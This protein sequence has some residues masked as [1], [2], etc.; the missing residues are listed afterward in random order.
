MTRKLKVVE[1]RIEKTKKGEEY[2]R[3]IFNHN[4]NGLSEKQIEKELKNT[5]SKFKDRKYEY[6]LSTLTDAYWKN[7]A[8]GWVNVNDK[9]VKVYNIEEIY[10]VGEGVKF[11]LKHYSATLLFRKI[12]DSKG[13]KDKHNDCLYNCL[14]KRLSS[15]STFW[16]YPASMKK[17]LKLNRD[18]E[19]DVDLIPKIEN[20]LKT[21]IRVYGDVNFHSGSNYQREIELE[22]KNGHYSLVKPDNNMNE[23]LLKDK[24]KKFE[25]EREILVYVKFN[26]IYVTYN[27]KEYDVYEEKEFNNILYKN[28]SPYHFVKSDVLLKEEYYKVKEK[29]KK[30]YLNYVNDIDEIKNCNINNGFKINPLFFGNLKKCVL[31]YIYYLDGL[32][33]VDS[34]P[35]EPLEAE[36]IKNSFMGGLLNC[37]KGKYSD[38]SCYDVNSMYPYAL[39]KFYFPLKKGEFLKIDELGETIRFGIYR[40]NIT[41]NIDKNLFRVNPSNYYTHYDIDNALSLG[42]DVELIQ[43]NQANALIYSSETRISGA[44]IFKRY[45]EHFYNLK[46]ALK[47]NT[48]AK[49][50]ITIVWG[51]LCQKSYI[52]ESMYECDS[53]DKLVEHYP[54]KDGNL[55]GKFFK[56]TNM[57]KYNTARLGPFLTSYTRKY[58]ANIM[59]PYTEQILRVHTDGFIVKGKLDIELSKELGK[60]KLEYESDK[61]NI[62]NVMEVIKL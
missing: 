8:R 55:V 13:G 14:E 5:I 36:F 46:K 31:Y 61:I 54:D 19:V 16:M 4:K 47:G 29:M 53:L 59:K 27:G 48:T 24:I 57:Y 12:K 15:L 23:I 56:Y 40:C 26:H 2:I 39:K 41:G 11:N 50:L 6:Q 17:F 20:K 51:V 3:L 25:T 10:E 28:F 62:K 52:Q 7:N 30:K 33:N 1:Q 38:I 22:L 21:S 45:I 44:S 32:V 37:K 43:D 60:I 18:D 58:M 49:L 42:Y 35:I 34:E 9:D